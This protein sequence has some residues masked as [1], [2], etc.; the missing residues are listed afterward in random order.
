M[1]GKNFGDS[2]R[3]PREAFYYDNTCERCQRIYQ[4]AR[5]TSRFCSVA[6]RVANHRS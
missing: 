1:P 4:A 2:V 5:R 6:C 3:Q